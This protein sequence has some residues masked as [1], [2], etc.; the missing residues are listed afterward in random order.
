M[1]AKKEAELVKEMI[2]NMAKMVEVESV[3]YIVSMSWI[4]KW[5]NYV[6]FD[7]QDGDDEPLG[8]HPGKMDNQDIIEPNFIGTNN[9]IVS[10]VLQELNK[11]FDFQNV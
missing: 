2:K 1:D 3:W 4:T 9:Q 5:Q 10:T 11:K 6:G 8:P 7:K